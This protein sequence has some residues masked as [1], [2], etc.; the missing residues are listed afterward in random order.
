MNGV[1]IQSGLSGVSSVFGLSGVC[2]LFGVFGLSG[3]FG[4]SV[5]QNYD[6][7]VV[8]FYFLSLADPRVSENVSGKT[9]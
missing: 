2:G 9:C 3:V 6:Q 4:F 1:R 7:N 5:Y 8:S